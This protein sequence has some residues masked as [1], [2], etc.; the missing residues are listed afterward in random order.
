MVD[1]KVLGFLNITGNWGLARSEEAFD[2]GQCAALIIR[3]LHHLVVKKHAKA[4]N[5]E[6]L[7]SRNNPLISR[8]N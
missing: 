4:F 7:D 8:E 5:G 1:L 2:H 6:P 3:S